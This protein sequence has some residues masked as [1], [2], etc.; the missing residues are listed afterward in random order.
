MTE[1]KIDKT[2]RGYTLIKALGIMIL[3]LSLLVS[4]AG[5]TPFAYIANWDS[6]TVSVI[7]TAINKV[8]TTVPVGLEPWGVAVNPTGT[9]AYVTN[10]GS[11][12]ISVIN[13]SSNAVVATIPVGG[14]P[15]GIA[16]TPDG[17]KAYVCK[18]HSNVSVIDIAS[19]TVQTTMNVGTNPVGV[20]VSPYGTEV[21]VTHWGDS[22]YWNVNYI[23]VIDTATNTVKTNVTVG[24]YN[25][26]VAF[27]SAGTKAY[28]TNNDDSTIS[29]VDTATYK[30]TTTVNV[31][32]APCGVAVN[33][34]GT[35]V[36]VANS[37]SNTVSVIDTATNTVKTNVT[38]GKSP[39][40]VSITPDGTKVYVANG[41][42]DTVSV[43]D[44]AANTVK[45]TVNVGMTPISR[46]Q[47]IV[48]AP[49]NF[50]TINV[51]GTNYQYQ[52]WGQYPLINLFGEKDVPLF[53]NGDPIWKSHVDKLAK[54][55]MDSKDTY[56]L[57][58]G[59]KLDLGQNYSIQIK[60]IDVDGKKVWLEFD[61]S[62]QYVDDYIVSTSSGDKTWTCT[63]D[64]I[65]GIKN[66]PVLK[67]HVKQILG[68][69]VQI[70]GIWLIDYANAKTLYT[71]ER[72][73][74]LISGSIITK[75]I[76]GVN[77]SFL[78]ELVFKKYSLIIH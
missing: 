10:W 37:G 44:T 56:T 64:N 24:K 74:S 21:Y 41:G 55:V 71:G 18:A 9:K 5:A 33:P 3:A 17:S 40:G 32:L 20:A 11:G 67:V 53:S 4:I 16:V 58:T 46:G 62:G 72:F 27:N 38:V 19:N 69:T 22:I 31:G 7:D 29:V 28:V 66:V 25:N 49:S 12:T 50:Y 68:N 52:A 14:Q 48:P 1:A 6:N 63:L 54:L 78:G 30:T 23:S 45:A 43:I 65:Q 77:A 59:K 36:Y 47:F 8:T 39:S 75:I 70:D 76:N 34:A 15:L 2:C 73:G 60:Q 42:S 26:E 61:K 13:T 57:G 51:V 35:M